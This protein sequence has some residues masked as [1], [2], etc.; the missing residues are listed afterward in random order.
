M[1]SV[2]P[3]HPAKAVNME[4]YQKLMSVADD[5]SDLNIPPLKRVDK[6]SSPIH[7][8]NIKSVS[9]GTCLISIPDVEHKNEGPSSIGISDKKCV[10]RESLP[11][12]LPTDKSTNTICIQTD[13]SVDK[14]TSPVISPSLKLTVHQHKDSCTNICSCGAQIGDSVHGVPLC[15]AVSTRINPSLQLT[16]KDTQFPEQTDTTH[17]A[18]KTHPEGYESSDCGV[19]PV[20]NAVP[21]PNVSRINTETQTDAVGLC[22]GLHNDERGKVKEK[23]RGHLNCVQVQMDDEL[24]SASDSERELLPAGQE[25]ASQSSSSSSS[26]ENSIQMNG[27]TAS[28]SDVSTMLST[29]DVSTVFLH[30]I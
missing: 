8:P 25:V 2:H 19:E 7:I 6:G 12:T 18:L 15:G 5:I 10:D 9:R 30:Q 28:T 3:V 20:D 17:D 22:I 14:S 16:R 24:T 29:S 21:V 23:K 4:H 11:T 13:K 27:T 26:H 1:A